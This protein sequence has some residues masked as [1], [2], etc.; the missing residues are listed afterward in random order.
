MSDPTKRTWDG[1]GFEHGDEGFLHSDEQQ[2]TPKRLVVPPP[3]TPPPPPQQQPKSAFRIVLLSML[4]IVATLGGVIVWRTFFDLDP[5][6]MTEPEVVE[7]QQS[8]QEQPLVDSGV[9]VREE[10]DASQAVAKDSIAAAS[11][12]SS[13]EQSQGETPRNET[14][15]RTEYQPR[16]S[17]APTAPRAQTPSPSAEAPDAAKRRRSSAVQTADLPMMPITPAPKGDPVYVV[18][19]VSSPDRDDAEEWVSLLR[20]RNIIDASIVEYRKRNTI[21]YR[22]RFGRFSTRQAAERAAMKVG[23]AQPWI[24]RLQ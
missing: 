2:A 9:V 3:S 21:W 24:A 17:A 18:Q 10:A 22:V 20:T 7:H 5:N 15:A 13:T 19:V 12:A 8:Q 4:L 6:S 1:S 16:A 23:V 11:L 14:K